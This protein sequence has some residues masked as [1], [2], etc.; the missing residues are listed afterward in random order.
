MNEDFKE[1]ISKNINWMILESEDVLVIPERLREM[2]ITEVDM[3]CQNMEPYYDIEIGYD[4]K[5]PMAPDLNEYIRS[6]YKASNFIA[7]IVD[8]YWQLITHSVL[9]K[10]AALMYLRTIFMC[11]EPENIVIKNYLML[12]KRMNMREKGEPNLFEKALIKEIK[13]MYLTTPFK[14]P[15]FFADYELTLSSCKFYC[16]DEKE[17][18]LFGP[19]DK[20][21]EERINDLKIQENKNKRKIQSQLCLFSFDIDGNV[22]SILT[23]GFLS[24]SQIVNKSSDVPI[25]KIIEN[26]ARKNIVGICKELLLA[27]RE[28][29]GLMNILEKMTQERE[30]EREQERDQEKH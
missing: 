1:D 21:I 5:E 10:D 3:F 25:R 6:K 29:P 2:F 22:L 12:I 15:S 11:F 27:I 17:Q 19:N 24:I 7:V 8:R 13:D 16:Y 23:D 4:M 30:Q 18:L 14:L 9:G 20:H 26:S 28:T